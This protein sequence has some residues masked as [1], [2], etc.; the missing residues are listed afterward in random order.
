MK[1]FFKMLA[2]SVV[3]VLTAGCTD[4]LEDEIAA[5]K[6][7]IAAAE[8]TC[9][10]LNQSIT[11][12]NEMLKA[13]ENNIFIKSVTEN[14]G[15]YVITFSNGKTITLT[16]GKDGVEAM[17]G[18]A[19]YTDGNYYWTMQQG[20]GTPSYITVN[21]SKMRASGNVPL[22]GIDDQGYWRI[23]YDNGKTWTSLRSPATGQEGGAIFKSI[24]TTN[25]EFVRFTLSSG[26]VFTVPTVYAF[27]LVEQSIEKM[28]TSIEN[29]GKLLTK[30]DS[31]VLVSEVAQIVENDTVVGYSIK[32]TDGSE[33]EL[34]NGTDGVPF[35]LGA[36]E[37]TDGKK[38]WTI[39]FGNSE[40][41]DWLLDDNGDKMSLDIDMGAPQ[42][43]ARDS[44]GEF[45]F[46]VAYRG[47]TDFN[48]LLNGNGEK[49]R[50]SGYL[51]YCMFKK[52]EFTD[53]A[54]IITLA[55]GQVMSLPF[56]VEGTPTISFSVAGFSLNEHLQYVP[57][58]TSYTRYTVDMLIK[59]YFPEVKIE[60]IGLDNIIVQSL[61]IGEVVT[62][63][64]SVVNVTGFETSYD[65]TFVAVDEKAQ[66]IDEA[67][68]AL[69][70][71]LNLSLILDESLFKTDTIYTFRDTE[72]VNGPNDTVYIRDTIKVDYDTTFLGDHGI[73]ADI[74]G[75]YVDSAGVLLPEDT[76]FFYETNYFLDT[77]GTAGTIT[78]RTPNQF[79][80]GVT[81]SRIMVFMTWG[82]KMTMKVLEFL[83]LN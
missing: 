8:N 67:L 32:M 10:Q 43:S 5:L 76:T 22:L 17:I 44:L 83:N 66:I 35:R 45:Y 25:P 81:S 7:R 36:A 82:Q 63:L 26:T 27:E 79:E 24:D 61:A 21:G 52:I 65:T 41:F 23:S 70:Q 30:M 6:T 31:T 38:Y 2:L 16:D 69:I 18:I 80:E 56:Y 60:A 11:S 75:R 51:G 73:L 46:T 20:G 15:S 33:V 53:K 1:R 19:Q 55:D 50:A 40:E 64:D 13:L 42:L 72:F 71:E 68:L 34:Y 77:L 54:V 29:L 12:L 39:S 58:V 28:N 57:G 4:K 59:D 9:L 3:F 14:N 48:W 49:V 62:E 47:S 74:D 78:F 37:D